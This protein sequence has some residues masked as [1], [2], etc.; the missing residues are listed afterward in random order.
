MELMYLVVSVDPNSDGNIEPYLTEARVFKKLA[1]AEKEKADRL[2]YYKNEGYKVDYD[3]VYLNY[4]EE[5]ESSD[6]W[7]DVVLM[8]VPVK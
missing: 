8:Q 3:R 4:D 5:D 1:D 7:F 2:A 6:S